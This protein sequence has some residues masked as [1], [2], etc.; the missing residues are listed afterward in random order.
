[1]LASARETRGRTAIRRRPR[2]R[3]PTTVGSRGHGHPVL[4]GRTRHET[5]PRSRSFGRAWTARGS[6]VRRATRSWPTSARG[7]AWPG[8]R[9]SA[10]R[11]DGQP[12]PDRRTLLALLLVSLHVGEDRDPALDRPGTPRRVGDASHAARPG[13][14]SADARAEP[15]A[16]VR[17]SEQAVKESG[18]CWLAVG[19]F[20]RS[21]ATCQQIADLS[22]RQSSC[23]NSPEAPPDHGVSIDSPST[24]QAQ[25]RHD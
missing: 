17:P 9:R 22:C 13:R 5:R 8:S 19:A 20:T 3:G 2:R 18:G 6:G 12:R 7:S 25:P 14:P 21:S 4:D 23:W 10:E 11:S 24:S 1:M 15:A 16:C